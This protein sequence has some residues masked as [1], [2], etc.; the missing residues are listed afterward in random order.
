[1]ITLQELKETLKSNIV[2]IDFTKKNGEVRTI[3]ATLAESLIAST[4]GGKDKSTIN[5]ELVV[6]TDTEIGQWRSFNFDQIIDIKN[7]EAVI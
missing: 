4:S 7:I 5:N 2:T 3:H 1:M 6:V